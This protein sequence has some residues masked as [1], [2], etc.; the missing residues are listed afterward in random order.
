MAND[1]IRYCVECG[2]QLNG[3]TENLV[4][5]CHRC[6]MRLHRC[7]PPV[8]CSVDGCNGRAKCKGYCEKHWI[9][10]HKYGNPLLWKRNQYDAVREH[11]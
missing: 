5:L 6:H 11:P 2:A 10:F 1:P 3:A 8:A 9:R 7:K 4:R